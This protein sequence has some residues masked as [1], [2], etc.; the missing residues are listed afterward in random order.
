MPPP[1][2]PKLTAGWNGASVANGG[3]RLASLASLEDRLDLPPGDG[4]RLRAVETELAA[5]QGVPRV[6]RAAVRDGDTAEGLRLCW[7]EL[8]DLDVVQALADVVR[9]KHQMLARPE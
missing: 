4:D 6:I 3:E 8:T 1:V 2:E 9:F 5:T 7:L